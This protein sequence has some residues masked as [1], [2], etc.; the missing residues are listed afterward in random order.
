MIAFVGLRSIPRIIIEHVLAAARDEIYKVLDSQTCSQLLTCFN[1]I[2]KR[3]GC[4]Q[5]LDVVL[6][7][8]RLCNFMKRTWA[9]VKVW[10]INIL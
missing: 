1:S 2:G 5:M 4:M 10:F 8:E 7:H 3:N 6:V 9:L